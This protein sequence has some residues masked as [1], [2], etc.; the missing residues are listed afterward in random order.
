MAVEMRLYRVPIIGSEA[1]GI[2]QYRT[3]LGLYDNVTR[4][5]F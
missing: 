4:L 2:I 1:L 5:I 3:S